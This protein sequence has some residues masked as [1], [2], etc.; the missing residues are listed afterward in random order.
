[1]KKKAQ[2]RRAFGVYME[3]ANEAYSRYQKLLSDLNIKE[4]E[5]LRKSVERLYEPFERGHFTLAILGKMSAGKSTFINALLG[6][7]ILPFGI[8]Q[9]TCA[10]T[11]IFASKTGEKHLTVT[12]AE[13]EPV[14]YEGDEVLIQL[15]R[16][17]AIPSDYD[18]L[19]INDINDSIVA[20]MNKKE[21]LKMKDEVLKKADSSSKL[22]SFKKYLNSVSRKDI[23]IKIC[24]DYPLPNEFDGWRIIDTPGVG[25]EGG[26]QDRT[27]DFIENEKIDAVIFVHSCHEIMEGVDT[28]RFVIK[29]IDSL[30]NKIQNRK[31]FVLTQKGGVSLEDA[32]FKFEKAKGCYAQ[33]ENFE[34]GF[35][36]KR[37]FLVDSLTEQVFGEIKKEGLD[38]EQVVKNPDDYYNDH[39]KAE[40]IDDIMHK[41]ERKI[42]K[43]HQEPCPESYLGE[44]EKMSGFNSLRKELNL[45]V[46][47]EKHLAFENLI[48][49]IEEDLRNQEEQ[50]RKEKN[51]E[52][53][54]RDNKNF[55]AL[56]VASEQILD[57]YDSAMNED[58][59][60]VDVEYGTGMKSKSTIR[61]REIQEEARAQI[62]KLT[63][64]GSISKKSSDYFEKIYDLTNAL[65]NEIKM[66]YRVL[67]H[68]IKTHIKDDCDTVRFPIID[69]G[70][71]ESAA[72]I[73][74]EEQRRREVDEKLIISRIFYKTWYG[75]RGWV[76]S[77]KTLENIKNKVNDELS[78]YVEECKA[79][80]A[81]IPGI[82]KERLIAKIKKQIEREKEWL[83]GIESEKSSADERME[84]IQSE[85]EYIKCEINAI[86]EFLS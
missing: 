21:I 67:S 80:V 48:R 69:F 35:L 41:I 30:S 2:I 77:E 74:A 5:S 79:V 63:E 18:G 44:I 78:D 13:G 40:S 29:D 52:K 33:N 4:D 53:E 59:I 25:A 55:D 34:N 8:G 70:E 49:E 37:F 71:I 56:I 76:S 83:K 75:I 3:K 28:R 62:N 11:E 16:F 14:N 81:K 22:K 20:G 64:I 26:I 12:F 42:K 31:F 57:N 23:P 85:L 82:F 36:P 10:L 50:K 66:R 60:E 61:Y 51:L 47:K 73:E 84:K 58:C 54:R 15:Q 6:E 17:A 1:M 38:I 32:D 68:D 72:Q 86:V 39:P 9:T 27:Y 65:S 7:E 19:P 24:L 46:E 43:S 45:F